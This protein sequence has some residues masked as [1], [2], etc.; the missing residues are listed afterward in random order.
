M[1]G[2]PDAGLPL[3]WVPSIYSGYGR[4][5]SIYIPFFDGC[6]GSLD[7]LTP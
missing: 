1:D 7:L 3:F 6:Y 2:E 4:S 5:G